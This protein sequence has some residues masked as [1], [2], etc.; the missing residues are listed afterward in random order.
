[1]LC[2]HFK[3]SIVLIV[4]AYD[5]LINVE[6]QEPQMQAGSTYCT[7]KH[8]LFFEQEPATKLV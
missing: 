6:Y 1:M 4:E 7:G 5:L 3:Y 2:K 8:K